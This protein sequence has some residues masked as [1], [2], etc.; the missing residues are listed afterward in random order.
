MVKHKMRVITLLFFLLGTSII[1]AQN[2]K[3]QIIDLQRE[4]DS[5]Q[6]I[7]D[8][9]KKKDAS[10]IQNLLNTQSELNKNNSILIDS[11]EFLTSQFQQIRSEQSAMADSII[12]LKEYN[13]SL[14]LSRKK[15]SNNLTL[16]T[17][18]NQ[19]LYLT[20]SQLIEIVSNSDLQA[21]ENLEN[22]NR[23]F[24]KKII[25]SQ[26]LSFGDRAFILSAVA[27][28][29][30][31]NKSKP[32]FALVLLE[33]ENDLWGIID[34]KTFE[35]KNLSLEGSSF[36]GNQSFV[37]IFSNRVK[38]NRTTEVQ[39]TIFAGVRNDEIYTFLNEKSGENSYDPSSSEIWHM[40]YHVF[41]DANN[42]CI[43]L[44]NKFEKHQLISTSEI[45]LDLNY[46]K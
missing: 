15:L 5:L 38:N 2:K 23:K 33:N 43:L 26:N 35:E 25:S 3:T 13:K 16:N 21:F 18:K 17:E 29:S 42:K 46:S 40:E 44:K 8:E 20:N 41:S 11:L 28:H 9:A 19:N 31:N 6:N 14:K 39:N 7:L 10:A 4:A 22:L 37:F 36:L 12:L 1:S 30:S 34:F 45:E 32:T 24:D 27:F